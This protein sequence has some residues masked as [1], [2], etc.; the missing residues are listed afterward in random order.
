[1]SAPSPH[2]D[3]V[4]YLRLLAAG[5]AFAAHEALEAAWRRPGDPLQASAAVRGLIQLAAAYVHRERG[6]AYGAREVLERARR[7]L[8]RAVPPGVA[9][10]LAAAGIDVRVVARAVGEMLPDPRDWPALDRVVSGA[11]A[12]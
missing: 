4:R 2:P 8:E 12:R 9:Q 6:N 5:E 7:N 10:A 11:R 3:V 1:L